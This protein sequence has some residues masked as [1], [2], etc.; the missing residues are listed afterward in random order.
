MEENR[1]NTLPDI[2]HTVVFNAPIQNVWE[3]VST[4]E[5][6]AAWWM[7]NDFQPKIGHEFTLQSPYG[8]SP[9]KVLELDPPNRLTFSWEEFWRVTFELKELDGKT[10]FTLIHSGWGEPDE[11]VPK[12]AEKQSVIRDRMDNGWEGIIND[13]LRKFVE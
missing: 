9:C 4:S 12:A 8:P 11:I 7:P 6:I 3:A 1:Q 5:G 10:Q 2:R 13:R